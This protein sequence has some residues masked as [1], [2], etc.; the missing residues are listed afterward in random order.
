MKESEGE[1]SSDVLPAAGRG[2]LGGEQIQTAERRLQ[3]PRRRRER[4]A[5]NSQFLPAEEVLQ[6]QLYFRQPANVPI[7]MKANHSQ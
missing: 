4:R 2:G 7:R 6:G 3:V 5:A 1:K